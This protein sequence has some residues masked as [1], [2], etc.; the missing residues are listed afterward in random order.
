MKTALILLPAWSIQNLPLGLATVATQFRNCGYPVEVFDLNVSCWHQCRRRYGNAWKYGHP[1]YWDDQSRSTLWEGNGSDITGILTPEIM[2][3]LDRVIA[4]ILEKSFE[5]FAFSLFE[6]NIHS[7]LYIIKSIRERLPDARMLFGGPSAADIFLNTNLDTGVGRWLTEKDFA[8]PGDAN[9]VLAEFCQWL[10]D[11]VGEPS[12]GVITY[13]NSSIKY[14]PA[15]STE[16]WE[17]LE[18][19]YSGFDLTC[20]S[21]RVIPVE[22]TRGCTRKCAYCSEKNLH[23]GYRVKSIDCL[24]RMFQTCTK[25]W[26]CRWYSFTGSNINGN[27]TFF[28][29]MLNR[30]LS[31]GI[32]MGWGGSI[33]LN[34]QLDTQ[35]IRAM[36]RSGCTYINTGIESASPA[37]LEKMNKPIDIECAE[38]ILKDLYS[39]RVNAA[40]NFIAGFP[41]ETEADHRISLNFIRKNRKYIKRIHVS[42][43]RIFKNTAL[44]L[45]PAQ[46]DIEFLSECGPDEW[47]TKC[48]DNTIAIRHKRVSEIISVA[49]EYGI[50]WLAPFENEISLRRNF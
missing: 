4:P 36:A 46:F 33:I 18:I 32:T 19:D 31:S 40:V 12:N 42:P 2:C 30:I 34:K 7:T 21:Q 44:S 5:L 6:G 48:G 47:A 10:K 27:F 1:L 28:M 49:V 25:R 14:N 29:D 38:R 16:N 22:I 35:T 3:H 41:G 24:M 50:Q 9:N 26:K 37:V 11:G 20:Y 13:R 15:T 17:N 23:A 8:I 45:H 43:C 39:V